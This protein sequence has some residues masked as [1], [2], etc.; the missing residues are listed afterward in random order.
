MFQCGDVT[1]TRWPG[2]P[3]QLLSV[4]EPIPL[5]LHTEE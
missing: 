4:A 1:A 2:L 3:F 5:D